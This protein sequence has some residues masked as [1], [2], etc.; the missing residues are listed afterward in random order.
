MKCLGG[1]A[2]F[3]EISIRKECLMFFFIASLVICAMSSSAY[4]PPTCPYCVSEPQIL[5]HADPLLHVSMKWCGVDPAPTVADPTLACQAPG[6][7]KTMLWRRHERATDCIWTPQARITLRS[8]GA[9]QKSDYVMFSDLS[10]TPGVPGDVDITSPYTELFATWNKCDME[11]AAQPKGAVAVSAHHLVNAAGTQIARGVAIVGSHVRPWLMAADLQNFCQ[12]NERSLAHEAGHLLSLGHTGT[13]GNL[14]QTGG[15][16]ATLD[17]AQ[18][19]TARAYLAG[20]PILDPPEGETADPELVDFVFDPPG[21]LRQI[22]SDGVPASG[23]HLDIDKIVSFDR[24]TTDNPFSL[25]IG[26]MG[27]FP[28]DANAYPINYKVAMDTDN[29]VTTGGDPKQLIPGISMPTADLIAQIQVER[30]SLPR[31]DR[32]V[33][34]ENGLDFIAFPTLF[35]FDAGADAFVAVDPPDPTSIL[36]EAKNINM[37]IDLLPGQEGPDTVPLFAEISFYVEAELMRA[38]VP[39]AIPSRLFTAGGLK[40]QATANDHGGAPFDMAPD[41]AEVLD[42]PAILFPVMTAPAIAQRGQLIKIAI[43]GMPPQAPLNLYLGNAVMDPMTDTDGEGNATFEIEIP[44]DAPLGPT[45]VSVGINDPNNA[46]TG[47]TSIE[48]RAFDA[49]CTEGGVVFCDDFESGDTSVWGNST[50]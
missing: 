42:F 45:L 23:P 34:G 11:W 22:N 26:V 36:A 35:A 30:I 41:V 39:G 31:G 3:A 20:C 6:D 18:I 16:G 29:D 7:F 32:E 10:G 44:V 21:D 49:G 17:N 5:T 13:A 37:E 1:W 33:A 38:L 50:P 19:A 4:G 28:E 15:T 9:V 24:T 47:D 43:E 46:I 8:G 14:M 27:L 2:R 40:L 12:L 25:H 48:I